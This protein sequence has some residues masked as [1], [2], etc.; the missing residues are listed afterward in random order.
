[1]KRDT[2]CFG[3]AE[4]GALAPPRARDEVMRRV[5]ALEGRQRLALRDA[6][7]RVLAQAHGDDDTPAVVPA[8]R[9]LGPAELGMLATLGCHEVRV[10]RR[11]RV[12]VLCTGDELVPV[13]SSLGRG[14]VHDSNRYLLLGLLERLNVDCIDLGIAGDTAP[15]LRSSLRIAAASAD[16]VITTGGVS[17]GE[18]DLACA[19]LADAGELIFHRVAQRPGRPM[20]FGRIGS[21][22]VF[23]LAGKPAGVLAGFRSLVA[24]ALRQLGGE[25]P[26]PARPVFSVTCASTLRKRRGRIEYCAGTLFASDGRWQVRRSRADAGRLA[27]A[28][29]ANCYIVLPAECGDVAAG[30][31]V[32]VQ[33]FGDLR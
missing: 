27:S 3:T 2:G 30:E 24:D 21:A 23:S 6:I 15:V 32:L 25:H 10:L 8:G 5:V 16:A 13:G 9:R 33:P 11:P 12:A 29:E 18:A 7:G 17:A 19:A 31:A 20:A 26:L 28:A 14:Q 22:W 1:M 4:G